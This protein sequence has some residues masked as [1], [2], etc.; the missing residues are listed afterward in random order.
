M[1]QR[2]VLVRALLGRLGVQP[3]S[4][5]YSHFRVTCETGTII[6][7]GC[8]AFEAVLIRLRVTHLTGE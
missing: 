2:C 4:E 1:P 3:D 5:Q 8:M 6:G 7:D